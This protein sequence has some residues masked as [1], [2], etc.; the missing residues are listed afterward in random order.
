MSSNKCRICN[1]FGLI[2][3]HSTRENGLKVSYMLSQV[4]PVKV[5]IVVNILF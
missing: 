2:P 5:N 3:I 4:A 1:D